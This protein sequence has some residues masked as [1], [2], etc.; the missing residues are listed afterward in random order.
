MRPILIIKRQTPLDDIVLAPRIVVLRRRSNLARLG[1]GR[2]AALAR[3]RDAGYGHGADVDRLE[4][5]GASCAGPFLRGLL[6]AVVVGGL[7]GASAA[8]VVV[9]G[10]PVEDDG[11][12]ED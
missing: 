3:L 2:A 12:E 8:G 5:A 11:G 6:R 7:A 10:H 4:G 9:E 1:P